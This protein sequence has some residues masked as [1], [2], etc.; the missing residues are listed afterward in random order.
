[1]TQAAVVYQSRYGST[2]RYAE[3]IA[4]AVGADLIRMSD[5]QP[6]ALRSYDR[7]IFGSPVFAGTLGSTRIIRQQ[8]ETLRDRAV[9]IFVV[10]IAPIDDAGRERA[11]DIS[12]TSEMRERAAVFHLPGAIDYSQ[13]SL[14]H[15]LVMK[16]LDAQV[17]RR[18]RVTPS[19]QNLR[20]AQQV[21]KN[22]D[23]V[24]RDAIDPIVDWHDAIAA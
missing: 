10:G 7:L 17:T 14:L 20:R 5:V 18:A 9:A 1:M 12:L 2:A 3:W 16:L 8:A 21:G 22:V 13:L 23:G 15:G 24:V 4:D 19:E 6:G 11:V